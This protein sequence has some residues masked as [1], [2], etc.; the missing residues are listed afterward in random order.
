MVVV[1][2]VNIFK[3]LGT[4]AAVIQRKELSDALPPPF[5]GLTWVSVLLQ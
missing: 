3:D 1:G 5:F 4:A 2:F